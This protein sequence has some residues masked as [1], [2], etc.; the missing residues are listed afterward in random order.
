MQ[1]RQP[2]NVIRWMMA[3]AM[4]AIS[5]ASTPVQAAAPASAPAQ[6]ARPAT[7]SVVTRAK[8]KSL[9]KGS[10]YTT[11]QCAVLTDGQVM[12]WGSNGKNELS[13]VTG[14]VS[15]P[16]TM[17]GVSDAVD[18]T[19]GDGNWCVL[20]ANQTMS[21]VGYN[22]SGRLG[23]GTATDTT[24]L[25][26]VVEY[27]GGP[28]MGGIK[29]MSTGPAH[30]CAVMNDGAVRCW[31][32]GQNGK[33]GDGGSLISPVPDSSVPV[34]V[35]GIVSAVHAS[36]TDEASC[37]VLANGNVQ[38]WG[39]FGHLGTGATADT[40][41]PQTVLVEVGGAA[42]SDVV[43]LFGSYQHTC[44]RTSSGQQYCWG[45]SGSRDW[46]GNGKVDAGYPKRAQ[47]IED[48]VALTTVQDIA[49]VDYG[50]CAALEDGTVRCWGSNYD[51]EVGVGDKASY[52]RAV[53][54]TVDT[55]GVLTDVVN[56][57]NA[58]SS[59]CALTG[60]GNVYCWGNG[61]DGTL[62]NGS[63][64]DSTQATLVIVPPP[65]STD[66]SLSDLAINPGPLYTG[67]NFVY[68]RYHYYPVV[69]NAIA[70][71]LVTPTLRDAN[72]TYTITG[73]PGACSPATS[74]ANCALS[75]GANTI[76]VTV[77]AENGTTKQN[78]VLHVERLALP[79]VTTAKVKSLSRSVYSGRSQC[80]ILTDGQVLCWGD[81]NF[82]DY[83]SYSSQTLPVTLTGVTDA[84]DVTG[85]DA[86]ICILHADETAS[87]IGSNYGSFGDGTT[88][89]AVT[90]V[91]VAEYAG[92]PPMRGIKQIVNSY[93]HSCAVMTNGQVRCWGDSYG[94]A[95]GNGTM[96]QPSLVP[97]TVTGITNAVQVAVTYGG[98]CAL[99]ANGNV[100]CWGDQNLLGG[101]GASEDYSV[102]VTVL[103]SAG[104]AALGGIVELRSSSEY[105]CGRTAAGEQYCWSTFGNSTYYFAGNGTDTDA[106]AAYPVRAQ[107]IEDQANLSGVAHVAPSDRVNCAVMTDGTV[108]CWG[109]N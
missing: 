17:T 86:R 108:R 35:T 53:T 31:G 89:D 44:A 20:H 18:V 106:V 41:V 61:G 40:S 91:Y 21:C 64:T 27:L 104:G 90:P 24:S 79:V 100:Q 52:T 42:L 107:R 7:A 4:L 63:L 2:R 98:S 48:Q 73:S 26:P 8:V 94:G 99:L 55:G 36:M 3:A 12:C 29:Q 9:S 105:V 10:Y 69:P 88:D 25:S 97:V 83:S 62:G 30:R 11:N 22:N 5:C 51:G 87:C 66:A 59:V 32:D 95:L 23:N 13:S 109:L 103:A 28:P 15:V 77:T 58:G 34:T 72:A 37:A 47:R 78:Y 49:V 92:G 93:E 68:D 45:T 54:V 38:C 57:G 70:S 1:Q 60:A 50:A 43:E 80:A 101:I 19:G 33:L 67:P 46:S 74:P 76:T 82:N 6:A 102:P 84:V 81:T 65:A 85:G 71:M 56:L 39:E 16:L 75:V 96:G 14:I